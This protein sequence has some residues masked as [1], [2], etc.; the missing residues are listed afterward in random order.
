MEMA[1]T[2]EPEMQL[3]WNF[4]SIRPLLVSNGLCN[5]IQI[6]HPKLEKIEK[7]FLGP[8]WD[9]NFEL[10]FR[11]EGVEIAKICLHIIER[12]GFELSE[13]QNR[14]GFALLLLE[15]YAFENR[16]FLPYLGP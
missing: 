7:P 2:P 10:N 6:Q 16:Y 12:Q 8:F 9:P 11:G 5:F 1:I 14:F 4:H 3:T 13:N 15:M